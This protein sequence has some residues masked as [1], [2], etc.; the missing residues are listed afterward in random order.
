MAVTDAEFAALES[1]VD[2]LAIRVNNLATSEQVGELSSQIANDVV[3]LGDRIST[4]EGKI[5]AIESDVQDL[6]LRTN[7][8]E[9]AD[10]SQPSVYG[11]IY[12]SDGATAQTGITATPAVLTGFAA[13]GRS[14]MMT[15][16][17]TAGTLTVADGSGDYHVTFNCSFGGDNGEDYEFECFVNGSVSHLHFD[18]QIQGPTGAASGSFGGILALLNGD[19]VDVRISVPGGGPATMTPIHMQLVAEKI[20]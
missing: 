18:R 16:D 6:K 3:T 12:L 10:P 14:S 7:T 9:S 11:E 17:Y 8:L 15:L 13:N 2:Q 4:N 1:K 5:G 20:G 19:V